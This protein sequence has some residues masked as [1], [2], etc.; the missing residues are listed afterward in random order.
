MQQLEIILTV[1]EES[2]MHIDG[3]ITTG[4]TIQQDR[5]LIL[6][7]ILVGGLSKQ[8]LTDRHGTDPHRTTQYL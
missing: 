5:I 1:L 7:I 6:L 3:G 4:L 2:L 8:T